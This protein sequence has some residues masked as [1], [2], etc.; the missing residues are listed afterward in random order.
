M[1][2]ILHRVG[3]QSASPEAVYKALTTIDGLRGW[4]TD[5]TEGDSR[6]GGIIKFRFGNPRGFFDMKVRELEPDRHVL[7]EVIDGPEEW[8]GTTVSFD[9]REEDGYVIVLFRH[10]G[11]KAPIEFMHHCTTK[12]ALFLM[13]LKALLET[14]KGA[15]HPHD[16]SIDN[17]K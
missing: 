15:P 14:G 7:W 2:D 11:W 3:I 13:S 5:D 10:Q 6:L 1:P 8:V 12:W 4:W 16:V 17:W 9:L